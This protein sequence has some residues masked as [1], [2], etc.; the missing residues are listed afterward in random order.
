MGIYFFEI[1]I[2]FALV[3]YFA[4]LKKSTFATTLRAY[5]RKVCYASIVLVHVQY[6]VF[7]TV[8]KKTHFFLCMSCDWDTKCSSKNVPSQYC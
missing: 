4:K 7:C 1:K 2:T 8:L 6:T 3:S 5:S